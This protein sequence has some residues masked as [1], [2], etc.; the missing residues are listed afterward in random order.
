MPC[1]LK[2][3]ERLLLRVPFV[4]FWRD[5]PSSHEPGTKSENFCISRSRRLG[6][7][8]KVLERLLLRVPFVNFWRDS[9]S[10]HEPGTKS[11]NFC[12]SCL[13]PVRERVRTEPRDGAIPAILRH[14]TQPKVST[15][16]AQCL[17]ENALS[18]AT[19]FAMKRHSKHRRNHA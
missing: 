11:E 14:V 1:A 18:T 19:S 8:W 13:P 2:R 10:S 9:P 4:N 6:R 16:I 17:R 3:L 7:L 15:T 5:S 12:I